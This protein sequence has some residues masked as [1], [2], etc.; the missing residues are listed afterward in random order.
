MI[1]VYRCEKCEYEKDVIKQVSALNEMERCRK[2]HEMERIIR[3][4]GNLVRG[5][6]AFE[7]HYQ[8]AFGKTVMT[9]RHLR[10]ELKRE[11]YENGVELVN[12]GNDRVIPK[13]E[14]AKIDWD[15]A[16]HELND[17]LRKIRKRG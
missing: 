11:K 6:L 2:G 16:G 12:V 17:R 10:D 7:P 3:W 1:Y 14:E 9:P 5:D 15:S 4:G 8:P 13:K